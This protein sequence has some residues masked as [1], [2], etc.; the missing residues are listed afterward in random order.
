MATVYMICLYAR[1]DMIYDNNEENKFQALLEISMSQKQET[2][3]R[4]GKTN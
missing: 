1:L 4:L 2:N 3:S